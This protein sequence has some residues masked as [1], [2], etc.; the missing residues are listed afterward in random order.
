MPRLL[1]M[2]WLDFCLLKE[3]VLHDVV[4]TILDAN[5][6]AVAS[7]EKLDLL[8]INMAVIND[9]EEIIAFYF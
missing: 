5:A 9:L 4:K 6:R 7:F 3:T 1:A 8:C 2:V